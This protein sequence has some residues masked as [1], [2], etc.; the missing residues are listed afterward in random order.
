MFIFCNLNAYAAIFTKN[1]KLTFECVPFK[2]A[3]GDYVGDATHQVLVKANGKQLCQSRYH[4]LTE[5][6]CNDEMLRLV[7]KYEHS[8]IV[9]VTPHPSSGCDFSFGK[10][11]EDLM[12][13]VL[14]L[15]GQ[16]LMT[17]DRLFNC[18]SKERLQVD[19]SSR[20]STKDT[21]DNFKKSPAKSQAETR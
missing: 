20:K 18:E 9:S 6:R 3:Q 1:D 19:Q 14:E 2:A 10:D 13:Q 7:K 21:N 8:S 16:L 15:K 17:S 5:D 12:E 11:A 4:G